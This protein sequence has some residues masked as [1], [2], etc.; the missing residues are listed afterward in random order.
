MPGVD[1]LDLIVAYRQQ[2]ATRQTPLIVLSSKEEAATKAEAIRRGA[3]D[4]LVKL[5][6]SVEL[7]A[8]IRYHSRAYRLLRQ[9]EAA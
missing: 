8:R 9:A 3:N 1:G 5:P 2:E 7:V 4:Y 6:Q